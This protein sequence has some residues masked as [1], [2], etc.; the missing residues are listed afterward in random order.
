MFGSFR[1]DPVGVAC[2]GIYLVGYIISM[3]RFLSFSFK[4]ILLIF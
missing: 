2:V 4:F 1:Y 3:I